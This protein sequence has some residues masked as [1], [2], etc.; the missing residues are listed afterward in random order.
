MAA[1]PRGNILVV[2]DELDIL[3][4]IEVGLEGEGYR[5]VLA[6]SGHEAL[7]VFDPARFELVI[8]D[9]KMPGMDG[10]A[11]LTRLRERAPQLPAIVLTGYLAPDTIERCNALGGIELVR[12]PF[13]FSDLSNL[14]AITVRR[15]R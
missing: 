13:A 2:D 1:D 3:E 12:K 8:C 9:I 14:V 6:H 15:G 4:M 5:V 11:M 10:I 7:D